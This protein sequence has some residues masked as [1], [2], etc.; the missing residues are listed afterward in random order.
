MLADVAGLS[1]SAGK[2]EQ[3]VP[4]VSEYRVY[5][6]PEFPDGKVCSGK[7]NVGQPAL[8]GFRPRAIL[9]RIMSRGDSRG[10]TSSDD[11]GLH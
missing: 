7:D 1:K 3:L 5:V 4:L 10:P 8:T 6:W 9:F 11:L 2:S